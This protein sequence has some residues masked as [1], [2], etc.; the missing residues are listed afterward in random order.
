[1]ADLLTD[2]REYLI[3]QG[4]AALRSGGFPS[5]AFESSVQAVTV[6]IY[7]RA[8]KAPTAEQMGDQLRTTLTDKR[9]WIMGQRT[10]IAS[11]EWRALQPLSSDEQAFSYVY[12]VLFYLYAPGP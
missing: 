7:L 4:L 10:V 8:T 1:M 2:M 6:D 12:S 11:D 3:A 5:R 9:N